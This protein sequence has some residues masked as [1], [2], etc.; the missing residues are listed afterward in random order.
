M[1]NIDE[2]GKLRNALGENETYR[3]KGNKF[4]ISKM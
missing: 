4:L 2:V 3:W 1:N